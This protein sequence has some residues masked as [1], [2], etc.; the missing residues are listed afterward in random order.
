VR[1]HR[2]SSTSPALEKG[3]HDNMFWKLQGSSTQEEYAANL[4][5]FNAKF[6]NTMAYLKNIDPVR[7]VRFAQIEA[8]ASTWGWRSN[9]AGEIGQ[10]SFLGDMRKMHP[11][12]FFAA[13]QVKNFS[14]LTKVADDHV[15]WKTQSVH[16]RIRDVV[17][18]AVDLFCKRTEAASNCTVEVTS[19]TSG[20]VQYADASSGRQHPRRVVDILKKTCD[21]LEWK[22]TEFPC[23][24]ALALVSKLGQAANTFATENAHSS[25]HLFAEEYSTIAKDLSPVVPPTAADLLA[26]DDVAA[27]ILAEMDSAPEDLSCV[28]APPRRTK[29]VHGNSKRKRKRKGQSQAASS[30]RTSSRSYTQATASSAAEKNAARQ[31]CKKCRRAGRVDVEF[32]KSSICPYDDGVPTDVE[33]ITLSDD[34]DD[35]E[36]L[37]Q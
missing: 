33:V 30:G 29:E 17:P 24:C 12:D 28:T 34:E 21:C 6:P 13:L 4:A 37:A 14:I 19:A 35:L 2:A 31:T 18:F 5:A 7:W 11:L 26:R 3:F 36:P 27:E 32:H 9:N 25:Y 15:V 1:E 10:G 22:E 16:Q 8:G 23:K 20:I